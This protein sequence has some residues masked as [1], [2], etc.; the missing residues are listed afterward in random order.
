VAQVGQSDAIAVA[1]NLFK[2]G[3]GAAKRLHADALPIF[4]IITEIKRRC[5]HMGNPVNPEPWFFHRFRLGPRFHGRQSI[6]ADIGLAPHLWP[7]RR[8]CTSLLYGLLRD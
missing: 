4:G 1:R 2:N 6:G 8:I 7:L 5:R 3:K